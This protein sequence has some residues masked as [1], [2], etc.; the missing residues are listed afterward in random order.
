MNHK[1]LSAFLQISLGLFENNKNLSAFYKNLSGFQKAESS[2]S[3]KQIN[4]ATVN[5]GQ[6]PT[7]LLNMKNKPMSTSYE[8]TVD[9]VLFEFR[10]EDS[11]QRKSS[12]WNHIQ[13]KYMI[14]F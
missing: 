10:F 2:G 1:N 11:V 12:T 4:D 8:L 5:L 9:K 13:G 14:P 7:T 3:T 6:I